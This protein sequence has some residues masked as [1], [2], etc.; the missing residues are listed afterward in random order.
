MYLIWKHSDTYN[1]HSRLIVLI[2]EICNSII[3]QARKF[4]SGP[5]I[6]RFMEDENVNEAV[7]ILHTTVEVCSHFKTGFRECQQVHASTLPPERRWEVSDDTLFSRLDLFIERC[8]DILDFTKIALEFSK[9]EKVHVGG[10]KGKS[11]TDTL[12]QIHLG[13]AI[14]L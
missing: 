13:N 4:V 2:R 11:L 7:Q 9:L 12:R 8:E 6:F 5:V 14:F 3:E 1:S 10:T